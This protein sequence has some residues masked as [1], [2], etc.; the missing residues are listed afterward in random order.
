MRKN[1]DK[2]TIPTFE[3]TPDGFRLALASIG[4]EFFFDVR[5]ARPMWRRGGKDR[6]CD[7][8]AMQAIRY[9]LMER[10]A[11]WG[12]RRDMPYN[13][14]V[15]SFY[16]LRD[17]L[18]HHHERDRFEDYLNELPP[19]DLDPGMAEDYNLSV[20]HMLADALGAEDD[21]Y[22]RHVSRMIPLAAVWR[23]FEPGCIQHEVPVLKG[24][25]GVGKDTVL[26]HLLPHERWSTT[27]FSFAMGLKDR[28]DATRGKVFVI[29]SE[30]GGVTTTRDLEALKS[31]VTTS[32]DDG[33]MAY[34]RDS[35]H[36]PRR[37]AFCC[38]TNLDKPLPSDPSG[39][40]RW[41]T[42]EVGPSK[43]GA[44]EPWMEERRQRYWRE[45]VA[46]Y[47]ARYRARLP[48]EFGE[49]QSES[50]T[51]NERI[52]EQ[53]HDAY[54]DAIHDGRLDKRQRYT[55]T[56]IAMKLCL[57]ETPSDWR[58]GT[59]EAQHRLRDELLRG[60]WTNRRGRRTN[61][62]GVKRLWLIED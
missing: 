1:E 11:V 56:E 54:V 5:D 61:D 50:N 2:N 13:L 40:R 43:V 10:C 6:Y 41:C 24:P 60:G 20:D 58:T 18:M 26:T 49:Y 62:N 51:I 36:M 14:G 9:E 34:R 42:V 28:I 12:S 8:R 32:H 27:S 39:N 46:L 35:E 37:F 30:M 48:R 15:Q 44:L 33:R 25:Q 17:A 31:Y 55:L 21:V 19:W 47:R 53:I 29:A 4:V 23:T 52:D 45:A 22:H 3:K 59:R 7:D 16:S 57:A 38:T